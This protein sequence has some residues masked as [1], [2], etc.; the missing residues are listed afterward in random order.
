MQKWYEQLPDKCPP[1][2]AF[3]PEGKVYYRLI[4]NVQPT[5]DDFISKSAELPFQKFIGID[6][7]VLKAVSIFEQKNDCE[8]MT[9]FPRHKNKTVYE[10][11]LKKEDGLVKKTFDNSHYSWWRSNNFLIDN[12]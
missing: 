7:C 6:D 11:N 9:K 8:K 10:L 3:E 4:N 12:N 5:S 1:K 2:D